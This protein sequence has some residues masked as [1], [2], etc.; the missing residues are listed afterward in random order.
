[1]L[2]RDV[3]QLSLKKKIIMLCSLTLW[4]G[5]YVL[6]RDGMGSNVVGKDVVII[7]KIDALVINKNK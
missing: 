6:G 2:G 3:W 5:N 7:I 1:M 4:G